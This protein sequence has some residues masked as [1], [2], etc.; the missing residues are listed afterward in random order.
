MKPKNFKSVIMLTAVLATAAVFSACKGNEPSVGVDVYAA[1]YGK[2]ENGLSTAKL[3]KNNVGTNLTD[4]SNGRGEAFSVFVSGNNVYVAGYEGKYAVLWKNGVATNLTDGSKNAAANCV[5]VSGSDVYVAG[6]EGDYAVLWKNGVEQKLS[7]NTSFVNQAFS[8]VVSGSNV[9]VGGSQNKKAALWKNGVLTTLSD[10]NGG[11]AW[12]GTPFNDEARSVFVSGNDVYVAITEMVGLSSI[13]TLWKN[14]VKTQLS[15]D[16]NYDAAAYSV[17]VLGND[18]Y[19][20]GYDDNSSTNFWKNGTWQ[21]LADDGYGSMTWSVFALG[22]DI[23]VAG[24][25]CPVYPGYLY[26]SIWKNGEMQ[27]LSDNGYKA[28]RAYSVFVVKK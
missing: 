6:Y 5:V 16:V 22:S 25:A 17:Y 7:D 15:S 10:G 23:Y 18:V 21:K 3:W 27:Y 13:A 9:Y 4:G 20:A 19:V 11:N 8:V 24:A 14:G 12:D 2:T 1:G 28:E 26:A